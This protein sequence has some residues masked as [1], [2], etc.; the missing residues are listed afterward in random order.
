MSN[1]L[2]GLGRHDDVERRNR[3]AVIGL[4]T[5]DA[6]TGKHP[7]RTMERWLMRSGRRS[8]LA[9]SLPDY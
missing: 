7:R 2:A 8:Q 4:L 9:R 3:E 1:G 5:E 6:G